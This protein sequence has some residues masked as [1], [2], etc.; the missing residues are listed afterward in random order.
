MNP[1]IR[2]VVTGH[3]ARGR[4]AK[5]IDEK[6]A[7]APIAPGGARVATIWSSDVIPVDNSI[8]REGSTSIM[9]IGEKSG[10]VLHVVDFP[11]GYSFPFHRT[12]SMDY[13]VVLQGVIHLQLEEGEVVEMTPGDVFV[14]RGTNHSWHN[15]SEKW[16]RMLISLLPAKPMMVGGK[17]VEGTFILPE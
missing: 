5:L 11:P 2:R 1:T 3:D 4:S 6:V 16:V 7:I 9:N 14:Q 17:K 8:D 10:S 12:V 15:R 13:G